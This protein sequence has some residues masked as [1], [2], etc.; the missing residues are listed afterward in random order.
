[1]ERLRFTIN[2][3]I[4]HKN[5]D[6]KDIELTPEEEAAILREWAEAEASMAPA[7]IRAR[8]KAYPSLFL[9][10]EGIMKYFQYKADKGLDVGPDMSRLLAQI[11]QVKQDFPK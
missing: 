6:G 10:I 4:M 3:T 2:E 9:Q 7:Y 11:A 5:I 8:Q 1:M